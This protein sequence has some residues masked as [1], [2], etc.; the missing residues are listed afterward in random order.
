MELK[1]NNDP[2]LCE[3]LYA[4]AAGV[5]MRLPQ[6]N[7][8]ASLAVDVHAAIFAHG[9]VTS[10]ILIRDFASAVLETCFSKGCLPESINVVTF[11]PPFNSKWPSIPTE[12]M[13]KSFEDDMSCWH[14]ASS[15]RCGMDYGDF[16]RYTM[17]AEVGHF[18]DRLL[19]GP[20][21][22]AKYDQTFSVDLVRLWITNR[23]QNLGW[24]S[25]RF[26][27]YE[28]YCS[29]G[30]LRSQEEEIKL[31]RISKK[32]QWIALHEFIGFLADHYW[33]N[34]S[35]HDDQIHFMGAWQL[36]SREFDPTRRLIDIVRN[37]DDNLETTNSLSLNY[38]DPFDNIAL[39][40]DRA[41]WVSQHP[42]DFSSL[43]VSQNSPQSTEDSLLTLAAFQEWEEPEYD[44]HAYNRRG[45]LK[46]WV[47]VRSFLVAK[48]NLKR[49]VTLASKKNF[50]GHGI[51]FPSTE[52]G[53]MG[54]YPWGMVFMELADYCEM[55]DR[56]VGDIGI[57]YTSTACSWNE[58]GNYIPSP[59]LCSLLKLNWAGQN[60]EFNN[61]FGKRIISHYSHYP[62]HWNQPLIVTKSD[63]QNALEQNDLSL[64]W[65]LVAEKSCWCPKISKHITGTGQ[66]I[67]AVYWLD[68]EMI[69]GSMTQNI[70][71]KFGQI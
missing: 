55:P 26:G 18:S 67:S 28:K 13:I 3:R 61:Q 32:Y 42:D 27:E 40:N 21:P 29:V 2:Y 45:V 35:W 54:E 59:Q 7:E 49:F 10:N 22:D 19:S 60:C 23:I 46:M 34:Q 48:K 66:E 30:R 71:R 16:G 62:R 6:G 47:S 68:K 15:L 52:H 31:E 25:E 5:A 44:R 11:R 51:N 70:L 69:K 43:L 58:G 14:I 33:M 39:C 17:G 1:D 64:V 63:L 56:R 24:T 36:Y 38:P 4:V 12:E 53:W 20:A 9:E 50:Y 37:D 65:C 41:A 8:L 57:P